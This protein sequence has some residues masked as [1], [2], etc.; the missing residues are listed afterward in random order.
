MCGLV[1]SKPDA[2]EYENVKAHIVF[3]IRDKPE[4]LVEALR[5]L[6]NVSCTKYGNAIN[7]STD[8]S[9]HG[10]QSNTWGMQLKIERP[11]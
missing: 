11:S 7:L 6:S 8:Y 4:E 9:L 2:P 3:I 1:D 10:M 5:L